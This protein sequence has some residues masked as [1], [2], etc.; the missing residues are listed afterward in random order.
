MAY[1]PNRFHC[2]EPRTNIAALVTLAALAFA[3]WSSAKADVADDFAALEQRFD[4][5]VAAQRLQEAEPVG[6]QLLQTAERFFN[7]QPQVVAICASKLAALYYE[8]A[9]PDEAAAL[10]RRAISLREAVFGKDHPEVA[11]VVNNLGIVYQSQIKYSEAEA[12]YRRAIAIRERAF[13]RAHPK[14]ASV[15]NNLAIVYQQGGRLAEAEPLFQRA[16]AI[17]QQS[18]PNAA[19]TAATF[20]NLGIL[21]HDQGRYADAERF[22][23]R[24]LAIR[25]VALGKSHPEVAVALNNLGLTCQA[26]ARYDEAMT[27]YR[28]ALAIME[29]TYGKQHPKVATVLQNMA[30][31]WV[32]RERFAEAEPL[33]QR[34]I[35]ICEAA[36]DKLQLAEAL[37]GLGLMYHD[38][39][40][41]DD[42]APMFRRSLA[43]QEAALGKNHPNIAFPLNNL[44]LV[45]KSQERFADAEP[46]LDRA[47]AILGSAGGE[48]DLY[49]KS[50]WQRA[51]VRYQTQR[52][53][54]ALA[55]LQQ[56]IETIEHLRG[57]FAG[58]EQDR[59]RAFSNHLEPYQQLFD[60][61]LQR[62]NLPEAFAASERLRARSLADQMQIQGIDLFAGMPA[63]T[64]APLRKRDQDNRARLTMLEKLSEIANAEARKRLEPELAA[65]REEAAQIYR[66]IRTASPAWRMMVRD[67]FEPLSL[68]KM[69]AWTNSQQAILLEFLVGKER[70]LV[71]TI[72]GPGA[73]Q[74]TKL[75]VTEAMAKELGIEPGEL[76][77]E[78]LKSALTIDGQPLSEVFKQP[79]SR[80]GQL[81]ETLENRLALLWQ[82]LI[83][84]DVQRALLSGEYKLLIV[85]PDSGLST[86]PFDALVVEQGRDT[87]KYLLDVGPPIVTAPSATLLYNLATRQPHRDL[88]ASG[89]QDEPVVLS[90]GNP[91]YTASDAARDAVSTSV[92]RSRYSGRRS[93]LK[94]LPFAGWESGWVAEQFNSIGLKTRT[95]TKAEATER[96][97]REHLAG[98]QIVH[99][100]CHG[101]TDQTHGNLFGGL[102]L[103]S[104]TTG[105]RDLADDGYLTLAEIYDLKLQDCELAILSACETNIGPQ[106]QGEGVFALSRGFLVAGARRVIASNW[107]VDDESSATL[108]SGFCS[109]LVKQHNAHKTL[110]YAEA[111]QTAK[112]WIRKQDKWR[113]PY[114]WG[115]FVQVGPQ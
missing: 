101:L 57:Q 55:D 46:L 56:S 108:I 99:L 93:D 79:A 104:S 51:Q 83:P 71:F 6:K 80:E 20:N 106:L 75:R 53:E 48:P 89:N 82:L 100:A 85:V 37:N 115:A 76:T 29:S 45:Y 52:P 27:M 12:L 95:L 30:N 36:G 63:A 110:N 70:S 40:R 62:G 41:F 61:Q 107:I 86:L 19:E 8:L 4:A 114:Y 54:L 16:L 69:Q 5:L 109:A 14:V 24:A 33:Y 77:A 22:Y 9:R 103:A 28:R 49:S 3:S 10:F 96:A 81:A 73:P 60:W 38:L 72:A 67:S 31:V 7:D 32:E 78:R 94:P 111:L 66:D 26:Q 65:A 35:Q 88:S 105:Q 17:Q 1:S 50:L 43:I 58:S 39:K 90:V 59:S 42:A 97:V 34:A 2:S 92:P 102:A 23:Q 11:E 13:G 87:T 113:H 68:E 47:L 84:T 44:A 74:V 25:E 21:Y 91:T 18:Q 64:A 98:R 15:L 112:R